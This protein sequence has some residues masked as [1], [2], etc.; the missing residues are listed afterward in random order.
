MRDLVGFRKP[1]LV[2][3]YRSKHAFTDWWMGREI[4]VEDGCNR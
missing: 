1:L 3:F 2:R 4:E